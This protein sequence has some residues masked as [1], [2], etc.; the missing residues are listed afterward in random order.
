MLDFKMMLEAG[1]SGI[2]TDYIKPYDL[3]IVNIEKTPFWSGR[4]L[5]NQ[6]EMAINFNT[7]MERIILD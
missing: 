4:I 2:Y 5:V 1:C 6:K 3:D 7:I